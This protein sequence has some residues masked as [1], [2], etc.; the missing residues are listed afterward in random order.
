MKRLIFW[1]LGVMF[2]GGGS[3]AVYEFFR[4]HDSLLGETPETMLESNA[5]LTEFEKNPDSLNFALQKKIIVIKGVLSKIDS[6]RKPHV[7]IMQSATGM[8][9]IKF[10]M[11]NS[12][13]DNISN[14]L[15][16]IIAVKL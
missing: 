12:F 7:L 10:V 6:E 8:S 14:D 1:F 9:S 16:K 4:G 15:G 13:N 2:L 5:L 3:F 11:D